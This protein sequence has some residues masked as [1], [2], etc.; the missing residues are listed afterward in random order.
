MISIAY[1]SFSILVLKG[2]LSQRLPACY[3][4]EIIVCVYLRDLREKTKISGVV[5][6]IL[7]EMNGICLLPLVPSLSPLW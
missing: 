4:T 6:M 5:P 7:D 3:E 2:N 1:W